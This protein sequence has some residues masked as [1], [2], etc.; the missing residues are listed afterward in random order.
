[1]EKSKPIQK[2]D[3]LVRAVQNRVKN[4]ANMSQKNQDM[5]KK[6]F[7][8]DYGIS[9]ALIRHDK[10]KIYIDCNIQ[11]KSAYFLQVSTASPFKEYK[12]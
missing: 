7:T 10:G 3:S 2:F 5:R 8:P 12:S 4:D 11:Q 1:M 9:G 6:D